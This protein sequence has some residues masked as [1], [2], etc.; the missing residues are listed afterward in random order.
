MRVRV[1]ACMH[2]RLLLLLVLLLLLLCVRACVLACLLA[3]LRACVR[4]CAYMLDSRGHTSCTTNHLSNL[5]VPGLWSCVLVLAWAGNTNEEEA[6]SD[7][8]TSSSGEVSDDDISNVLNSSDISLPG[9]QVCA[10]VVLVGW[11]DDNKR[12]DG[13]MDGLACPTSAYRVGLS[14]PLLY[15]FPKCEC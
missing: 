11:I 5:T 12:M 8:D 7:V 15:L 6:D 14:W 4:V 10:G 1:C 13:R 9:G 3:S 2:V